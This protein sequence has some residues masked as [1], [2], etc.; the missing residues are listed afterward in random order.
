MMRKIERPTPPQRA[1]ADPKV[2]AWVGANAGSGKTRVL[3][4][5]VARLLLAGT[6]PEKI[7][8]LTYTKAAAAEMQNRLFAMLGRWA[9]DDDA[10]L[11]A[12]LEALAEIAPTPEEMRAARRL[13]ARALETPGGL[14]IQTIHA[15]CDQLLRRYP[16]EAGVSPGFEVIEDRRAIEMIHLIREMLA[17]EAAS[18][19]SD[20]FDRLAGRVADGALDDL[21]T[22]LRNRRADFAWTLDEPSPEERLTAHFGKA[23]EGAETVARQALGRLDWRA[24]DRLAPLLEDVGG[25]ADGVAAE[26]IRQSR[27]LSDV[28]PSEAAAA[29]LGAYL[30]Q[31]GEPRKRK[32]FPVKDVLN[33]DPGAGPLTDA[34]LDWAAETQDALNAAGLAGRT[35]D[36]HLFA[37]RLSGALRGG[38]GPPGAP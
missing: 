27:R 17:E 31:K 8:C 14:K 29:L 24:L 28:A 20:A 32:G 4:H 36:L 5:R 34:M 12:E 30:T 26:A 7:L 38:E 21:I 22:A 18:G 13:F 2:S 37:A 3:T 35:R 1:A 10:V 11:A 33:A 9:M 25:K 23:T 16:L 15:F 19:S 6:P